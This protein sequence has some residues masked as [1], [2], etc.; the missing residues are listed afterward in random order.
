MTRILLIDADI[1][2]YR[3]AHSHQQNFP[4]REDVWSVLGDLRGAKEAFFRWL[5][6][7]EEHL[8]ADEHDL[9]LSDTRAN[10]R[11]SVLPTYKGN[12]AAW[13]LQQ[14]IESFETVGLPTLPPKPGPQRPVL[15]KPLRD[16][17]IADL[18]ASFSPTLEGDDLCSLAATAP[19]DGRERVIV[20]ADKDLKQVPGLLYNPDAPDSDALRITEEEADRFHLLQ[21]LSGDRT[22][23][24]AGCPGIGEVRAQKLLD[25]RG[26]T[27]DTV[28][29]AYEAAGLTEADALVQAQVARVL[30][31]GEHENGE[32]QLW[33]PR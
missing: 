26:A 28:L 27:W 1:P 17:L 15:H 9:Y 25:K 31:F 29:D 14:R 18:G 30:R 19:P 23:N 7:L 6:L 22:D 24:Y 10:W 3:I 5:V 8:G 13:A 33:K 4:W 2:L 16:H 11:H 32:V 21:T 20:S 12:R